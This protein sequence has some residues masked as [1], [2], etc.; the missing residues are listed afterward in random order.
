MP[1]DPEQKSD[2]ANA[3]AEGAFAAGLHDPLKSQLHD[4]EVVRRRREAEKNLT[5]APQQDRRG[6]TQVLCEVA[7]GLLNNGTGQPE[8]I[9][10]LNERLRLA[11]EKAEA[12][13]IRRL[14]G[15]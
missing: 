1:Y 13:R 15:F 5:A 10:A 12:E 8:S 11:N 7:A 6:Y 9:T 2:Y 3:V 14:L 4:G